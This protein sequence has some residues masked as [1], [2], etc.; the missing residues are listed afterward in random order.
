[1]HNV[2]SQ[3]WVNGHEDFESQQACGTCHG[4]TGL[5]TVISKAAVNRT[6]SVEGRTVFISK[7]TQIG[8]GLCHENEL[9]GGDGD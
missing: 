7:G 1:M 8:C 4:V 2:N 5:G 9:N 6:F 3:A